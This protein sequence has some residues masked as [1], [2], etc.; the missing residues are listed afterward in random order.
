VNVLET[1]R[2][3]P[4]GLEAGDA[5]F[6]VRRMNGRACGR[7]AREARRE[8]ESGKSKAMCEAE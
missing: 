1:E 8:R 7:R 4:R 6:R 3:N 2:L 5:A